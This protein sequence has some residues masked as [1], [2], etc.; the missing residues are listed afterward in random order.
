[1]RAKELTLNADALLTH[2]LTSAIKLKILKLFFIKKNFFISD[3]LCFKSNPENHHRAI[4][5]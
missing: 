5:K 2:D 3:F 4:V 1:M